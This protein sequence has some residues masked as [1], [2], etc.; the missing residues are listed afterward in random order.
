M[1]YLDKTFDFLRIF[2]FYTDGAGGT[3]YRF[4]FMH[5]PKPMK[6]HLTRRH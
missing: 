6:K 1:P 5:S 3:Y 4:W 2:K